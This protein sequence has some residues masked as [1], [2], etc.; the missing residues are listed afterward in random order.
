MIIAGIFI[1]MFIL[2]FVLVIAG[3]IFLFMNWND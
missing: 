3:A 2:L 1:F